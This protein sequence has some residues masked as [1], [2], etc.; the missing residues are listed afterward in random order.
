VSGA[1]RGTTQKAKDS[2]TAAHRL[3]TS[4]CGAATRHSVHVTHAH[5]S[6][7]SAAIISS[8][9]DSILIQGR[10]LCK[11]SLLEHGAV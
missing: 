11:Y 5:L 1:V 10:K 4:R 2:Y 8:S 6:H 3:K 9:V 7:T